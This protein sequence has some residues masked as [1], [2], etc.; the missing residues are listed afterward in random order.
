MDIVDTRLLIVDDEEGFVSALSRRLSARGIDVY[1]ASNGEEGLTRLSDHPEID[2]V[3]LDVKM[4]GID[5]IETLRQIKRTHPLVEVIMLTGHATVESAIDGMKL[6]AFD[7]LMKP[8]ELEELASKL[9]QAK[10]KKTAHQAKILEATGKE[11][12]KQRGA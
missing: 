6:G 9:A 1:S 3:L 7:Y 5:G 2:I 10:A 4:P 11:L 12:R 8:C